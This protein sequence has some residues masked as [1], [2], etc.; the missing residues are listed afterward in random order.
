MIGRP[1]T[2][3]PATEPPENV[4][5]VTCPGSDTRE[6]LA[7]HRADVRRRREEAGERRIVGRV[8]AVERER[9]GRAGE[10]E[11][12]VGPVS[13]IDYKPYERPMTSSMIS[14]VPAPMRLS[15]RSRHARSIPYS[16]M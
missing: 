5:L 11:R 1:P 10:A 3:G 9:P 7:R 16:R 2:R 13:G 6:R 8:G 12:G 14:S 15:R 4:P